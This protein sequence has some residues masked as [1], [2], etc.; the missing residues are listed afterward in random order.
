VNIGWKPAYG[1]AS[2]ALPRGNGE[3]QIGPTYGAWCQ[4]STLLTRGE[5]V[6]LWHCLLSYSAATFIFN[7]VPPGGGGTP[8]FSLQKVQFEPLAN[9][10][11]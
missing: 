8:N 7:V 5:E 3:Q 11:A 2:E 1:A 10:C 4:S 9:A 6:V